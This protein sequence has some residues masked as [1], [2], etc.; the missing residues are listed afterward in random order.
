MNLRD[1]RFA[2]AENGA[3]LFHGEFLEVVEREHALLFLRQFRD[4]F[5]EQM[6]ESRN[7]GSGRTA[8]L[9]AW[10]ATESAKVFFLAAVS[11]L[12]AQAADF[13]CVEFREQA[14][15]FVEPEAERVCQIV[16]VGSPAQLDRDLVVRLFD[17][18]ALAAEFA[19]AP[20]EFPQAVEDGAANAEL[21]V[22]AELN[23]LRLVEF[24]RERR[25][26]R[27]RRREPDPR[28]EHGGAAARECGARYSAPV[29][30]APCRMRSRSASPSML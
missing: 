28:T 17:L 26:V 7:V 15:K 20:V 2:N 9:P 5:G 12:D 29:A 8:S 27:R 30:T 6:L 11:G 16:F 22:G 24:A 1:A 14:L 18:A 25:S 19:R 21:G 10:A 3:Y 23:V 4:G 13:E